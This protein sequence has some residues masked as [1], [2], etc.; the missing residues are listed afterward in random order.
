MCRIQGQVNEIDTKD[1]AE[2]AIFLGEKQREGDYFTA[3]I[4]IN[5]HNTRFKL[6]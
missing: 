6:S 2:D 3:Q 5:H 1:E 4:G